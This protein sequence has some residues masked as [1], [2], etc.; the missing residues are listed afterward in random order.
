MKRKC[1]VIEVIFLLLFS[2]FITVTFGCNL[3]N[4]NT[5]QINILDMQPGVSWVKKFGLPSYDDDFKA[6]C[7]TSDGGYIMTGYSKSYSYDHYEDAYLV[8]VDK[9]GNEE[10]NKT[11]GEPGGTKMDYAY[12][13]QQTFDGG[14]VFSG[15]TF[16]YNVP[17]SAIWLVKTDKHGNELWNKRYS[18][19]D[20]DWCY[21]F[22]TTKDKGFILTGRTKNN[23]VFLLKT[24][25][26]GNE[27]WTQKFW[28]YPDIQGYGLC[29][30]ETFDGGYIATGYL[31]SDNLGFLLKT[32]SNGFM[33]WNKTYGRGIGSRFDSVQQTSDE[34]FIAC[35]IHHLYQQAWLVKTDKY[36]NEQWNMTY[37]FHNSPPIYYTSHAHDVK[38]TNDGG[39]ILIGECRASNYNENSFIMKTDAYGNKEWQIDIEESE[40][41]SRELYSVQQTSDGG[42]IVAGTIGLKD[43]LL[44]KVDIFENHAPSPPTVT[45]P[46]SGIPFLPL[47]YTAVSNDPDDDGLSYFFDWD[48]NYHDYSSI[49]YTCW[50]EPFGTS[51]NRS[52]TWK[53]RDIYQIRVK[54]M[55]EHGAQSDWTTLEVNIAKSKSTNSVLVLQKLFQ[56]FPFFEKILNNYYK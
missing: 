31:F 46:K 23:S 26:D 43:G 33:Q 29:V 50:T 32:D 30:H 25:K 36:G 39:Y 10:C 11:F 45:G 37:N 55:D 17:L 34:G 7:Q 44:I 22:Q 28:G 6:V 5:G 14:Y 19:G 12:S 18:D 21:S 47:T 27:L 38:L 16:S 1:L 53:Q 54:A 35:G 3:K 51:V 48:V 56:S 20:G 24:D 52:H 15:T 9:F 40:T 8:K 13:V 41:G 2:T 49:P 42:Y 4:K